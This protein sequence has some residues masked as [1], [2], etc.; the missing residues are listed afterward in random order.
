MAKTEISQSLEGGGAQVEVIGVAALAAVDNS[1]LNRLAVVGGTETVVAEGVVVRVTAGSL[2][3]EEIL[4]NG[5]N[6]L[7]VA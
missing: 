2:G 3:V 6:E 4:A 7:G 1:D 5:D